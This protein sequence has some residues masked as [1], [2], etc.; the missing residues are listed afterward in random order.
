MCYTIKD[1]KDF[2]MRKQNYL[3]N[4]DMLKEIHKSKMTYCYLLDDE[5][6]RFDIIVD[7]YQDIFD[8]NVVQQAR[9]NRAHQLSSE[10]Y[11]RAYKK[12]QEEGRRAKDKPKQADTRVNPEDVD[13][14]SLIYRV[15]TYEH[16]PD[17]P[18]RKTNPKSE[19]DLHTKTNFPPFKHYATSNGELC[20][21][22]RSHWEGGLDNGKFNTQHG[23]TTNELAKMYIKLCERYSMRSN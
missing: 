5:Y 13:I 17:E 21:V 6:E 14:N 18:K 22:V 4:K 15:M 19:A 3:N 10:G 11:E 23:T 7:D 12:W 1:L 8:P 20:E 9:E 2:L 16:V